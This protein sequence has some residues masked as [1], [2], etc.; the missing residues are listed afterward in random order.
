MTHQKVIK[1]HLIMYIL[2]LGVM[3][4]NVLE[5]EKIG[6]RYCLKCYSLHTQKKI[7]VAT[8]TLHNFIRKH[9]F[10]DE[11]FDRCDNDQDYMPQVFREQDINDA[12]P[13][14]ETPSENCAPNAE[15]STMGML[16][17]DYYVF[18]GA[19]ICFFYYNLY[20]KYICVTLLRK[21]F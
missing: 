12:P 15:G 11:E 21:M 7:V 1:R 19:L 13:A 9:A 17:Y 2:L 5:F 8:A 3:L 20:F 16:Q 6:L 10:E 18:D 14:S 4:K